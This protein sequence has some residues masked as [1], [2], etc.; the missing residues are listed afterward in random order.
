MAD[1]I[2]RFR[3]ALRELSLARAAQAK[4]A[5]VIWLSACA[6]LV[7]LTQ[8]LLIVAEEEVVRAIRHEYLVTHVGG[9]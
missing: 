2:C 1:S 9:G 7:R 6:D 3:S 8:F 5:S 4:S